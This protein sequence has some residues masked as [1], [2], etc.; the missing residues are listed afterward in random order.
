M[1]Y[2][3]WDKIADFINPALAV[4]TLLTPW[5]MRRPWRQAIGWNLTAVAC[6]AV[7]YA[8]GYLD[9]RTGI[10]MSFGA[11][12]S[13][14][15]AVYTAF[16]FVLSKVSLAHRLFAIG[17]GLA[18]GALMLFQKYHTAVDILSTCT[19]LLALLLGS[20]W[21]IKRLRAPRSG[22]GE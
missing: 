15:T 3:Q 2:E 13:T 6:V 8:M 16:A 17:L 19:V 9:S 5:V 21:L 14:H 10:W 1:T 7:A 22:L 11:D 4:I 12:Y 18:Y 20:T